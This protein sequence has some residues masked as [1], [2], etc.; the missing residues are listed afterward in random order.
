MELHRQDS[1][2]GASHCWRQLLISPIVTLCLLGNLAFWVTMLWNY[3]NP[4]HIHK[5]I[6]WDVVSPCCVCVQ[7]N[8][9]NWKFHLLI[10]GS[11]MTFMASFILK[12]YLCIL[13]HKR[14]SIFFFQLPAHGLNLL[15]W[16]ARFMKLKWLGQGWTHSPRWKDA[17]DIYTGS[18]DTTV[19]VI[20]LGVVKLHSLALCHSTDYLSLICFYYMHIVNY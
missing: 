10:F 3:E 17:E 2:L 7:W 18:A 19:S 13:I 11:K 1:S 14:W 6:I 20:R 8:L 12:S 5:A 16:Y 4:Q 9:Y 15:F